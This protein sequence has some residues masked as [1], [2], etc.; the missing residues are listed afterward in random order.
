MI[1]T[2]EGEGQAEGHGFLSL[3]R[4]LLVL[5]GLLLLLFI[6][7]SRSPPTGRLAGRRICI[8][9]G[10]GGTDPGAV[11]ES[12]DLRESEI[13]LDISYGLKLLL[14][15]E[16]ADVVMTR[17][18]DSD[19]SSRDRYTY[20]GAQQATIL[21]SV[22]TNSVRDPAVDG[23]LALYYHDD[24]RALAQAIYD[25]MV[26]SLGDTAPALQHFTNY[27][28]D[29]FSSALLMDSVMPAAILEPVFMSNAAEAQLLIQPIFTD[30]VAATVDE[31]CA[32]M[33]CRRG[34]IA[35]AICQG[36]LDYLSDEQPP[37]V[38]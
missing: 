1:Q 18:A 11:N 19:R 7:I 27:G 36:V 35:Q 15:K 22:H 30:H 32:D 9:P 8:D 23:S 24:D 38:P 14:E 28:L 37:P 10:H 21:V 17:T 2:L 13:N 26:S 3:I 12:F 31:R 25:H 4:R 5:V 34:Q 6:V 29:H 33:S 16:G 20:C